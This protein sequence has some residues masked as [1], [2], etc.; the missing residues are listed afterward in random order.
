M[1]G[2]MHML[3]SLQAQSECISEHCAVQ[4]SS[5]ALHNLASRTSCMR[6]DRMSFGAGSTV[7][8]ERKQEIYAICSE[9]GVVIIEDDPYYYL[10]FPDAAGEDGLTRSH[11]KYTMCSWQPASYAVQALSA[12]QSWHP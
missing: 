8:L 3:R 11:L 2:H 5:A 7:P 1:Q 10:Q 4:Y 6:N 9:Y 12:L